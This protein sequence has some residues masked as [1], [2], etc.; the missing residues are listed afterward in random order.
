MTWKQ[1]GKKP[2]KNY[3][4][5]LKLRNFSSPNLL[6]QQDE[7]QKSLLLIEWNLLT[8]S[9]S[10]LIVE[11]ITT[12]NSLCLLLFSDD[13]FFYLSNK[14]NKINFLTKIK[15]IMN[16]D[17][18]IYFILDVHFIHLFF[19]LDLSIIISNLTTFN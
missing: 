11:I 19:Y 3:E 17:L 5:N 1:K 16:L 13:F 7:G 6:F 9:L 15:I 12:E 14:E 2:V 10:I 4:N 18:N 8:S